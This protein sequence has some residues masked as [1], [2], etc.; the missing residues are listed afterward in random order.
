MQLHRVFIAIIL[1]CVAPV[2][3]RADETITVVSWGGVYEDAQR[4][5]IL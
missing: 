3:S 4:R 2:G 5:A 1:L